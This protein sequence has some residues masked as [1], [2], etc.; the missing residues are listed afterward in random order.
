MVNCTRYRSGAVARMIGRG[1]G[2]IVAGEGASAG[3]GSEETPVADGAGACDGAIALNMGSLR[4]E[5]GMSGRGASS[6]TRASICWRLRPLALAS[7]A[8]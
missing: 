1:V 6:A 2:T 7:T 8:W 3:F 4:T 5:L